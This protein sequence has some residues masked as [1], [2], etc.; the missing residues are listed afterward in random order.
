MILDKRGR[1]AFSSSC[2]LFKICCSSLCWAKANIALGAWS[3]RQAHPAAWF[4]RG[5]WSPMWWSSLTERLSSEGSFNAA[6]CTKYSKSFKRRAIDTLT[7]QCDRGPCPC[8]P[9]Q[10][11]MR[12]LPRTWDWDARQME[13]VS[14]PDLKATKTNGA[15]AMCCPEGILKAGTDCPSIF[16]RRKT[17]FPRTRL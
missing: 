13:H 5:P 3:V 2:F 11:P 8:P 7:W 1:H 12:P 6:S 9:P 16:P 14:T 17:A 4:W 15:R 10:S